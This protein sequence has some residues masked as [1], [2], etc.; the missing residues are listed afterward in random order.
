MEPTPPRRSRA[1]YR[2]GSF[3]ALARQT[4]EEIGISRIGVVAALGVV[5]SE[6]LP[7]A[8]S[9]VRHV[10]LASSISFGVAAS[11]RKHRGS[12]G[13]PGPLVR[14]VPEV[15]QWGTLGQRRG[16]A[17][18]IRRLHPQAVGDRAFFTGGAQSDTGLGSPV[19]EGR[20]PWWRRSAGDSQRSGTLGRLQSV[21]A[22]STHWLTARWSRRARRP[23]PSCRRGARLSASVSHPRRSNRVRR[24]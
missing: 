13:Q 6:W 12:I 16:V 24:R 1:A 23:V 3:E 22:P 17:P 11:A 7:L 18:A 2:R 14:S 15:W 19:S 21:E 10:D 5:R 9:V 4:K 20:V 8:R